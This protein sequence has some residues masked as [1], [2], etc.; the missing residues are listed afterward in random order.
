MFTE[1]AKVVSVKEDDAKGGQLLDVLGHLSGKNY[2][3]IELLSLK[4]VT[5]LPAEGDIVLVLQLGGNQTIALGILEQDNLD[6]NEGEVLLHRTTKTQLGQTTCYYRRAVAK[7]DE[8]NQIS[9]ITY[10]SDG[11]TV[12]AEIWVKQN[13][14]VYVHGTGNFFVEVDGDATITANTLSL[15]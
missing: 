2:V 15:P 11:E 8:D 7:I 4:G 10:D 13:G 1:Y 9:L 3:N 6:L 14:G 5:G 12:K